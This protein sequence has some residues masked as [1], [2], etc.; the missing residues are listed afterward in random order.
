[1]L[2]YALTK[3]GAIF[4]SNTTNN[5]TISNPSLIF[6]GHTGTST[7]GGLVLSFNS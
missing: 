7:S 2:I 6:V 1:M 3:N 5:Q 4:G